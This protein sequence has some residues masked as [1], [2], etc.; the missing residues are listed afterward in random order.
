MSNIKL[1]KKYLLPLIVLT[2]SFLGSTF[3]PVTEIFKGIIS[4]PGGGALVYALYQLV[5]DD[6]QHT[7]NLLLQNKQQ[8]FILSTSSHVAE[9]AYDKHVLFCEEY[10]Q[11]VQKGRQELFQDG[12][13][14][15]TINIG[16]DLVGI[17]QKHSAW[18]TDDIE[19]KLK[20]FEQVLIKIGAK[21]H[22]LQMSAREVMNDKKRKTIDDIYRSLGLVLGHENPENDQEAGL[23]IDKII[24]RIRDIL[25]IKEITELRVHA[26]K[27]ALER[28][29]D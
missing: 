26:T 27:V 22:Y 14:P 5:R 10:I 12:A 9:V 19:N 21:E 13:S 3:L 20:P 18:L 2:L 6:Q 23:N 1:L 28:L 16:G 8:D 4:L 29:S 24:D 11:R 15:K 7:R 25:G 17:R